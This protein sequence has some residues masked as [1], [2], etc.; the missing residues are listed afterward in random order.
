MGTVCSE[1]GSSYWSSLHP[2]HPCLAAGEAANSPTRIPCVAASDFSCRRGG[3]RNTSRV[4]TI[5]FMVHTLSL[6]FIPP[7]AIFISPLGS[8]HPLG[9]IRRRGRASCRNCVER[10]ARNLASRDGCWGGKANVVRVE[11][12]YTWIILRYKCEIC[13]RIKI[14]DNILW[15]IYKGR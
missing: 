8:F 7:S 3:H 11:W 14:Q 13:T 15:S 2:M 5:Y 6:P 9:E 4:F 10:G 12:N 1:C